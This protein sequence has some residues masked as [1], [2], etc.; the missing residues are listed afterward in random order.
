MAQH[1]VWSPDRARRATVQSWVAVAV[2]RVKNAYIQVQQVSI[3]KVMRIRFIRRGSYKYAE[4]ENE[5]QSCGAGV[6]L[7]RSL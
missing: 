7:E 6:K 1:Q 4:G 3:F 5:K 2:G